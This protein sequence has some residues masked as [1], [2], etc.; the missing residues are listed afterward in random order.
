MFF[1]DTVGLLFPTSH[2]GEG[3]LVGGSLHTT[4]NTKL[5]AQGP[6]C[7]GQTSD[8]GAGGEQRTPF[9]QER[10]SGLSRAFHTGESVFGHPKKKIREKT[11]DSK[12]EFA[13]Y[14]R[15]SEESHLC[16]RQLWWRWARLSDPE[17][18]KD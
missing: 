13:L 15:W 2:Q 5:L 6:V 1:T 17:Q 12:S 8:A 16:P 10:V 18:E 3:P 14:K 9:R 11:C 7:W 4:R